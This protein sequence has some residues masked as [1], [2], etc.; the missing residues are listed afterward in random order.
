MSGN[1]DWDVHFDTNPPD[2]PARRSGKIVL[3]I[4][5][6]F[7]AGVLAAATW[8]IFRPA[9]ASPSPSPPFTTLPGPTVTVTSTDHVTAT[10]T[11]GEDTIMPA[12]PAEPTASV[13][14]PPK[15]TTSH[16][17]T[18]SRTSQP[19]TTSQ[20]AGPVAAGAPK[21]TSLSCQRDGTKVTANVG[22]TTNG[23]SGQI[24][25]K[26]GP[27]PT[28]TSVGPHTTSAVATA[29]I[30]AAPQTCTATITTN[31]GSDNATT[32]SN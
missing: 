26:I 3:T 28:S 13:A 24:T 19:T 31:G 21:I 2:Q 7:L 8:L 4:A 20:P 11:I 30:A 15:Q 12:E 16:P 6:I 22:F 27:L 18:T 23:G 10:T 1:I 29:T 17:T 32:T 25:V 9:P 14:A 5:I